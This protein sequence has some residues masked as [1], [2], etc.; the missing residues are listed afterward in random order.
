ME[1]I[2]RKGGCV[3]VRD[4]SRGPRPYRGMP[5]L[6][7]AALNELVSGDLGTWEFVP[8]GEEGGRPTSVFRLKPAA[9]GDVTPVE[10]PESE[11][12]GSVTSSQEMSDQPPGEEGGAEWTF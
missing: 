10:K 12:F 7:E 2:E 5:D 4:L 9:S 8:A 1:W 11:G 3:T 6:A